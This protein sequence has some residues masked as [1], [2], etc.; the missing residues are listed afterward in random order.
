MFIKR[1]HK[2]FFKIL[3]TVV[4]FL[5]CAEIFT[6]LTLF[7]NLNIKKYFSHLVMQIMYHVQ[8]LKT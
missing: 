2:I 5:L 3:S 7:N 1:V 8:F 4:A 6:L